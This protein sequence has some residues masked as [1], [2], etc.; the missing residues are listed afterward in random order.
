MAEIQYFIRSRGR[1]TGPHSV[2]AVQKQ[3]RRGT[4]SKYDELSSD[5]TEWAH[6]GDFV[7]LFPTAGQ[8]GQ[9]HR[10]LVQPP[11][12]TSPE[13][14]AVA[15]Y[16]YSRNGATY[17]PMPLNLLVTLARN[18]SL[19]ASEMVWREGGEASRADGVPYL[20][21]IFTFNPSATTT[22][23]SQVEGQRDQS[24]TKIILVV[25]CVAVG[26]VGL[27]GL[28][29]TSGSGQPGG[30]N[31]PVTFS[32]WPASP[33]SNGS[34]RAVA[35]ST[36]APTEVLPALSP[37]TNPVL[38]IEVE[39][40]P[41]K[42]I[43]NPFFPSARLLR[44]L[45]RESDVAEA[46]GF[47]VFG[48]QF[49]VAGGELVELPYST[50]SCFAVS[51]G[52]ELITNKH[53][54]SDFVEMSTKPEIQREINRLAGGIVKPVLWVFFGETKKEARL[55]FVSAKYDMAILHVDREGG[56]FLAMSGSIGA[57]RG[58]EAMALGF[59]GVAN[60][61]LSVHEYEE[62]IRQ[63]QSRSPD[64]AMKF[65]KRDFEYTLT[66]GT[67][68]RTV[69]ESD[70]SR[71]IQH[72]AILRPGNSGGPLVLSSGLVIGIN[73]QLQKEAG[74]QQTNMATEISQLRDEIDEHVP[75][76]VWE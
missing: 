33:G 2:P 23:V 59:P 62:T 64:V 57:K 50:G 18:G 9:N 42:P 39:R 67:I 37:T 58:D 74:A 61:P 31:K 5:G 10:R 52:G 3:A 49:R 1:I 24:A 28:L 55:V 8:T 40:S 36:A 15:R 44:S 46:V 48:F 47:V 25:T 20:A 4:L 27:F 26:L 29:L 41:S 53:V 12:R 22:Q 68:S 38:P 56:L 60:R 11:A 71:W 73:T 51:P 7:D 54:V 45:A 17:G 43:V 34:S 21:S 63:E 35:Q 19:A 70:G 16:F 30:S 13:S 65:K 6:A 66:K 76:V 72:E 69:Q 14:D 75:K 32:S